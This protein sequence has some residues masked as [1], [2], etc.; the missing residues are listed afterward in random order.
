MEQWREGSAGERWMDGE[1]E[2]RRAEKQ[3]E[4]D[5]R[6]AQSEASSPMD[7]DLYQKPRGFRGH[8]SIRM[9]SLP[10]A[11]DRH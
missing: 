5:S 6:G 4:R 2:Q 9:T 1:S 3:I 7:Q 8:T 11:A 10:S